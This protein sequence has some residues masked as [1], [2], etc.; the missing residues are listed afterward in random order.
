MDETVHIHAREM[1][2]QI[3]KNE[4]IMRLGTRVEA[5]CYDTVTGEIKWL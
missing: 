3:R 5:A 4:V 1:A 2:G